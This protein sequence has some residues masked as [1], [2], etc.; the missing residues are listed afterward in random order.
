[1]SE[2][3]N[4]VKTLQ[5][6]KGISRDFLL[7]DYLGLHVLNIFHLHVFFFRISVSYHPHKANHSLRNKRG[8]KW[9]CF[10]CLTE[11]LKWMN[12]LETHSLTLSWSFFNLHNPLNHKLDILL[13]MKQNPKNQLHP[14]SGLLATCSAAGERKGK[15][16]NQISSACWSC[17]RN[18]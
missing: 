14:Q 5:K 7:R 16:L 2:T 9:N 6:S 3:A 1:M 18:S 10:A 13:R 11:F 17:E 4:Q 15:W 8:N 12:N